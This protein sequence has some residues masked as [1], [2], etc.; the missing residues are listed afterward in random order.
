VRRDDLRPLRKW[1]RTPRHAGLEHLAAALDEAP[2]AIV[3]PLDDDPTLVHRPV[4]RTAQRHEIRQLGLAA[5]G[6]VLDVV[7][8]DVALVRAAG[9]HTALVA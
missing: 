7:P 9:E 6:P 8:V 5:L 3:Q 4:M 2:R 1:P